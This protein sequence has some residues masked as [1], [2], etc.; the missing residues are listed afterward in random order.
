VK[1]RNA[2]Q[3]IIRLYTTTWNSAAAISRKVDVSECY[4]SRILSELHHTTREL[5]DM[6]A[7]ALYDSILVQLEKRL[8]QL[9]VDDNYRAMDRELK[10]IER[11]AKLLGLDAPDRVQVD[12][13]TNVEVVFNVRSPTSPKVIDVEVKDVEVK[14][15]NA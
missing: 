10:Y 1:T 7:R 13:Q 3:S 11:I 4:V 8:L 5:Q 12:A 2:K 9:S 6:R 14:D 15:D